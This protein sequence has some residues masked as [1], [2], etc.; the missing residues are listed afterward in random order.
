MAALITLTSEQIET[1]KAEKA[2]GE[3]DSKQHYANAYYYLKS[4]VD[5]NIDITPEGAQKA[6]LKRLSIWLDRAASIN[7]NDGSFSSEFV[8][9]ATESFA[10]T[11]GH[12]EFA[13]DAYFQVASNNLA[14]AVIDNVIFNKGIPSSQVIIATDVQ[15]AVESFKIPAWGWAGTIGDILP[16]FLGG[17]DQDYIQL[18]QAAGDGRSVGTAYAEAIAANA[19]GFGRS[20]LSKIFLPNDLANGSYTLRLDIDFNNIFDSLAHLNIDIE[21]STYFTQAN[22]L[23]IFRRDPLI[24]DLD[25]NGI[26]TTSPSGSNPILFDHDGSG[27]KVGTGWISSGDAFVVLDRNGNGTIDNGTELFGDSTPIPGGTKAENGFQ[28]LSYLD[29]NSDGKITSVDTQFSQLKVWR[30]LN[31]DGISQAAEL[32][33]LSAAGVASINL[34]A[35]FTP[36]TLANGNTIYGKGTFTRTNGTNGSAESVAFNLNLVE[37]TF[38][39]QFTT[40]IPVAADVKVLPNM[41]GSGKVRDLWEAATLSTTVKQA[42][43]A[44][45]QATT[46]ADQLSKLDTLLIAWGKTSDLALPNDYST[47]DPMGVSYSLGGKITTDQLHT[48]ERFNGRS[49]LA[50]SSTSPIIIG[51]GSAGGSSGGGAAIGPTI[52]FTEVSQNYLK[53]AYDALKESVYGALVVQTRLKPYLDKL[54][55]SVTANDTLKMDFAALNQLFETQKST[56]PLKAVTEL[57]ELNRFAGST[58][59]RMGW[60]GLDLLKA[61]MDQYAS[62]T[63][64]QTVLQSLNVKQITGSGTGTSS[65][66]LLMGSSSSDT[67]SAGEGNDILA[68]MQGDDR[69]LGDIG[70]DMLDGGSGNDWLEGGMGDDFLKGGTGN[71]SLTGDNGADTYYIEKNSGRD[72][73]Y[74]FE[75]DLT[76]NQ[77]DTIQF[78]EGISAANVVIT[79]NVDDLVISQATINNVLTVSGYFYQNSI[80]AYQAVDYLKFADGT[81]LDIAAVK[82]KVLISTQND[83]VL[84]GYET[85]DSLNGAAG[86]DTLTGYEGADTLIGG[87]GN[88]NLLGGAGDDQLQGDAGNDTLDSDSGN[89][90][91]VGGSGDD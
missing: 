39:R 46:R 91:L 86:D 14:T 10:F 62:N 18:A 21:I 67:L 49:I 20:M 77:P 31:Q 72:I 29:S 33:T 89:D 1:L 81:S 88:D 15:K 57:A 26:Q 51:A 56:N 28:A 42:L 80:N 78:G 11:E 12:P 43:I 60:N 73:I 17:L 90:K 74:N 71:D 8:R 66:E 19:Y 16:E 4:I 7:S 58:L 24:L 45:S 35:N 69:L 61:N 3:T 53:Q 55:L 40:V 50:T 79:R 52:T 5:N 41:Q 65:N 36:E 85:D 22:L 25:N 23:R 70:N 76:N 59:Y 83:D 84:S 44:F 34:N 32:Q 68:G 13:N 6:D 64:I 30:D 82:A 75:S 37:D 54:T 47:T 63:D 38:H 9:G 48:L 27:V 87:E 2:F